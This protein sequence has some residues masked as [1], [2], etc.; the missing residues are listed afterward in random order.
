M[1]YS[2][3]MFLP[4][5]KVDIG[6]FPVRE[7][8]LLR[9][10]KRA[11]K[12]MSLTKDDATPMVGQV[13]GRSDHKKPVLTFG[14]DYVLKPLVSD[15]RGIREVCFYEALE[16]VSQAVGASTYAMFLN[17]KEA[18]K[19]AL[20]HSGEIFDTI[21]VA[22]AMMLKDPIVIQSEADLQLAWR[23]VRREAEGLHKLKRFIPRYYG[24][25][26]QHSMSAS[27]A[28]PFG[29]TEDAY[30][31]L[32]SLTTTFSK[33]CVMDLKM[34]TQTFEPDAPT[35]KRLREFG[36]YPKQP[37]FGFRIV[38]MRVYDPS[39]ADADERGYRLYSKEYGRSL[40]NKAQLLEAFRIFFSAG[41]HSDGDSNES[42]ERVRLRSMTNI[43]QNI[44]PLRKWFDDNMSLEF[45]ASSLLF[46]YEGDPVKGNG[47][48]T[49]V[50]MI[51]FG[52]VRRNADGDPGYIIGLKTLKS[53]LTE[54]VEDETQHLR[55]ESI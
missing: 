54:I 38:G 31:L 30:L 46:I 22:L 12:W 33:P 9:A 26:G 6:D 32:H 49:L 43:L 51:D 3:S 5:T 34:G 24:V 45:R 35:E 10:F 53:L 17:G 14:T 15:H 37:E 7:R 23:K 39:H 2:L 44:R 28:A 13:G 16:A 27:Y 19:N 25:V 47:D 48:A 50:K 42:S 20:I 18:K 36:K 41:V 21:A 8:I 4:C 55:R 29:I 52:H 11:S 1:R 40:T